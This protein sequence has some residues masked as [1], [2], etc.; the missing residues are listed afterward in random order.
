MLK[1]QI[2]KTVFL[3][4]LQIMKKILDLGQYKL[5]KKSEDFIY[6]KQQVM[7]ATYF[8]L[9]KL[10]KQLSDEKIIEKCPKQCNLKQGY[11]DCVCG[12]S[13]YINHG[14]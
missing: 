8:N 12:G 3:M 13:G 6:Y 5:G 7:E 11:K 10:Y 14:K 4:N 2:A 1:I 9:K